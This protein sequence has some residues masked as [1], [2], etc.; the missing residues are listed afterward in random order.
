MLLWC[1]KDRPLSRAESQVQR[2]SLVS[3]SRGLELSRLPAHLVS[4]LPSID[5]LFRLTTFPE[6]TLL[7]LVLSSS[8]LGSRSTQRCR[9]PL[10]MLRSPGTWLRPE[11]DPNPDAQ[12]QLLVCLSRKYQ[13]WSCF[14]L[15]RTPK[16]YRLL[17]FEPRVLKLVFKLCLELE[18]A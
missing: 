11:V 1:F 5:R 16:L 9:I 4:S 6:A 8:E 13:N 18:R 3:R 2:G 12:L 15:R 10:M 17:I 7:F 14:R